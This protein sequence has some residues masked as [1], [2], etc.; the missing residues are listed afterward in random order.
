[1]LKTKVKILSDQNYFLTSEQKSHFSHGK[2]PFLNHPPSHCPP[3]P[4]HGVPGSNPTFSNPSFWKILSLALMIGVTAYELPTLR[5]FACGTFPIGDWDYTGFFRIF[6]APTVWTFATANNCGFLIVV[7]Q[8][9]RSRS[10]HSDLGRTKNLFIYGQ[11]LVFSEFWS[12][13]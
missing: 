11:S 4:P 12:D 2:R 3:P 1:M 10:D 7:Y 5:R 6:K 13:Q 9:R 8:G